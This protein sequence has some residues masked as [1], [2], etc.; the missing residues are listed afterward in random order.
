V[1]HS[2]QYEEHEGDLSKSSVQKYDC[3]RCKK[4]EMT[5]QTWESHCGSY[6][7]S[8]YTCGNCGFVEWYDGPDS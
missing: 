4:K 5:H 3:P 6:E 7:D 2:R 8:K 1:T